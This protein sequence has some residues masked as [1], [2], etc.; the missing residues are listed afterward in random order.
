MHIPSDH[1]RHRSLKTRQMLEEGVRNGLVTPT[2]MIAHGR[3]EAFDYL[4]GERTTEAAREAARAAAAHLLLASHPVI[5][6]NGNSSVLAPEGLKVLSEAVP[7]QVEVN[8]F[9]HSED[10]VKRLVEH[11]QG[12]GLKDV[13]GTNARESIP[14]L[15]SNRALCERDGIFTADVVL[16]LLEDGDRTQALRDMG[17]TVLSVDLN[18]LSRTART[19]HVNVVDELSR[20]LDVI[21]E[22]IEE[23]KT[24]PESDFHKII[25]IYD[26][27]TNL[28]NAMNAMSKHLQSQ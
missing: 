27:E 21:V 18:P 17:K 25:E 19:A 6:T 7:C 22:Y 16:V 20:A 8:L 13:L 5:S 14:S 12:K 10:R 11:L 23:L 28:K 26:S 3:G 24:C 9:H 4:L 2:G 1:P 15:T